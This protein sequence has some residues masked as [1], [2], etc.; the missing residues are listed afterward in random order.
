MQSPGGKRM[1]MPPIRS[2]YETRLNEPMR[3]DNHRVAIILVCLA[4]PIVLLALAEQFSDE[5]LIT[6]ISPVLL[7][8]AM[9]AGGC[10]GVVG[11]T[12]LPSAHQAE[13]GHRFKRGVQLLLFVL[14]GGAIFNNCAW[15][16][17]DIYHFALTNSTFESAAYPIVRADSKRRSDSYWLEISPYRTR[18]KIYVSAAQYHSLYR[19]IPRPA[20]VVVSQRRSRDGAIEVKTNWNGPLREPRQLKIGS[21]SEM[22]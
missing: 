20:C 4:V 17:A 10:C 3:V 21:C 18:A 16:L 11:W 9:I 7:W 14:L 22:T 15:Q 13:A 6:P 2:Q 5:V 8:G 1:N 12:Y 19:D